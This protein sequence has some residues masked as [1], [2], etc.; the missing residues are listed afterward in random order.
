MNIGPMLRKIEIDIRT[1]VPMISTVQAVF[2]FGSFF[3][4][5]IYRD[6]DLVV[7]IDDIQARDR[8][9]LRLL[10]SQ[11]RSLAHIFDVP[12]DLVVLST[13]EFAQRPL[14]DMESLVLI[15]TKNES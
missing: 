13:R 8:D 2:G 4:G 7:L 9:Y 6:V 14:R 12:I 11:F 1:Y 10:Y 15:I 3:R 5:G